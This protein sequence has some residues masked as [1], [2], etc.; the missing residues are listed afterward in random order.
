MS[1]V[2]ESAV[3]AA[4]EAHIERVVHKEAVDEHEGLQVAIDRKVIDGFIRVP[5]P[6][7][8]DH[9]IVPDLVEGGANVEDREAD[10]VPVVHR[11]KEHAQRQ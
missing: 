9:R 7:D 8:G 10:L 4:S 1:D 6:M 3:R 11:L 2:G 5:Q